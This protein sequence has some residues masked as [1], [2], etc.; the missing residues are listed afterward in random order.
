[1]LGMGMFHSG[2]TKKSFYRIRHVSRFTQNIDC[3]SREYVVYS[4]ERRTTAVL[5]ASAAFADVEM[6][7]KL[8]ALRDSERSAGLHQSHS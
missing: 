1:M 4:A 6:F 2:S 5:S 3:S 8:R 7:K